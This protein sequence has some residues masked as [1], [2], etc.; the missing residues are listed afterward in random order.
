[1]NATTEGV[2]LSP[3]LLGI[4]LGVPPSMNATQELVVPR[5]MP[6]IFAMF[7]PCFYILKFY[8]IFACS[9]RLLTPVNIALFLC[10]VNFELKKS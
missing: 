3:S 4:T 1:V 6:M 9:L 7:Y 2:V 10:F 8:F 5:S